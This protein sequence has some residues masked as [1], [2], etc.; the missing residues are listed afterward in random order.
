MSANNIDFHI[1]VEVKDIQITCFA[2]ANNLFLL[3]IN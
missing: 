1:R 3:N 2:E